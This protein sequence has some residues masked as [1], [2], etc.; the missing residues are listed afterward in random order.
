MFVR[1]RGDGSET[2]PH[3]AGPQEHV[4]NIAGATATKHNQVF[5]FQKNIK[6]DVPG[7]TKK[8]KKK[9]KPKQI[10]YELSEEVTRF[11]KNPVSYWLWPCQF[12]CKRKDC[13]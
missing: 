2:S 7:T 11:S 12:L 1:G 3:G 6:L 4:A 9:T 13:V 5:I 10:N 8:K